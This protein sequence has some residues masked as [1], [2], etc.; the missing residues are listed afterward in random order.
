[1]FLLLTVELINFCNVVHNCDNCM[2]IIFAIL[3]VIGNHVSWCMDFG[4]ILVCSDP[5]VWIQERVV[6]S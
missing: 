5:M 1:M 3:Y 4:P 6:K 2:V